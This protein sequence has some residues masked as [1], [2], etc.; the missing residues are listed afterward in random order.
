MRLHKPAMGKP[1]VTSTG[2][3][4]YDE[5]ADESAKVSRRY[6]GIYFECCGVYA[7]IYRRCDQ[8]AYRGR[9]PRCLRCIEV[10]VGP[11]GTNARLFRAQ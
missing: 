1:L 5:P 3:D 6:I 11:Q 7:R 10:R 2:I 4:Q 8:A 9:C